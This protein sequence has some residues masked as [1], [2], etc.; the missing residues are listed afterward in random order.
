MNESEFDP[1][2]VRL[3]RD[4]RAP[5]FT[6]G[7]EQGRWRL[8]LLTWPTGLFSVTAGDGRE[9]GIRVAFDGY[10]NRPPAGTPW[11]LAE[12]RPAAL[13][14]LPMGQRAERV[15]RS[16]WSQQSGLTPY[17]A[18]ERAIITEGHPDWV[19]RYP[20]RAWTAERTVAF[21]LEE[22]HRELQTCTIPGSSA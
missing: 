2:R 11:H 10:P 19:A 5:A 14:D 6:D 3:E 7:I 21:Y 9:F 16:A 12:D 22:L 17:M 20:T 13:Q 18:T 1:F 4:L 15:F 8:R